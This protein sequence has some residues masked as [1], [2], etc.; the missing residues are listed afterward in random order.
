MSASSPDDIARRAAQH[1][2]DLDPNL[3]AHVEAQLRDE[4]PQRYE[5]VTAFAVA[6]LIVS[7]AKLAWDVYTTLRKKEP[8]ASPTSDAISHHVRLEME[9]PKGVTE[10]Q[11]NRIIAVA[12]Q[13][14]MKEG[15]Q[16]HKAGG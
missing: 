12:V 16:S 13:E 4:I 10:E 8:A 14:V 15:D 9:V 6:S 1:L 3:P 7:A 2:V 5:P 11:Q